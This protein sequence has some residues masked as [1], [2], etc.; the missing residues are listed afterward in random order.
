MADLTKPKSYLLCVNRCSKR[1]FSRPPFTYAVGQSFIWNWK[2]FR[3]HNQGLSFALK[4]KKTVISLVVVLFC[5]C[6]PLAIPWFVIAIIINSFNRMFWG[7]TFT[8]VVTEVF[9]LPPTFTDL[10]SSASV[11]TPIKTRRIG[12]S[13]QHT[14]PQSVQYGSRCSVRAILCSSYFIT[15]T[16]ATFGSSGAAQVCASF[17]SCITALTQ[18]EPLTVA[19]EGTS[20]K[21]Q[22]RK[23]L[24]GLS[25]QIQEVV[26]SWKTLGLIDNGKILFSHMHSL[27]VMWLG[28]SWRLTGVSLSC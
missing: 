19:A 21:L 16:P 12:T 20:Y 3:P 26:N 5:A 23:P 28:S 18:T 22:D 13:S 15:I 4:G 17:N 8:H 6:S 27:V 25:R 2:F 7:R 24:N 10:Y 1:S 9:K 11:V 14:E